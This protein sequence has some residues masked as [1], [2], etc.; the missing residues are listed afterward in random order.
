MSDYLRARVDSLQNE[1]ERL[2]KRVEFLE[3]HLEVTRHSL[4]KMMANDYR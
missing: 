1:V 2:N 3:A 4:D